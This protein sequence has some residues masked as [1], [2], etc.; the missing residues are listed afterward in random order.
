MK[1]NEDADR[2][3]KGMDEEELEQLNELRMKAVRGLQ[4]LRE[5]LRE[6]HINAEQMTRAARGSPSKSS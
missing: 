4:K 3:T 5:E 1:F 6:E 2:I